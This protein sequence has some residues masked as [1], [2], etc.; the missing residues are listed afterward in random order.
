M[1][2]EVTLAEAIGQGLGGP[3]NPQAD[4][5]HHDERGHPKR[6]REGEVDD[7]FPPERLGEIEPLLDQSLRAELLVVRPGAMEVEE[8]VTKHRWQHHQQELPP[9]AQAMGQGHRDSLGRGVIAAPHLLHRTSP[10]VSEIQMKSLRVSSRVRSTARTRKGST[11]RW[12]TAPAAMARLRFRSAS[13]S[14]PATR[15][16]RGQ[17]SS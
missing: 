4:P 14:V 3:G 1:E 2:G 16:G 10:G 5:V 15:M 9:H 7:E 17:A 13:S 12:S 11:T 6:E 8:G